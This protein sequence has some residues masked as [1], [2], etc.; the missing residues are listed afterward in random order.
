M[1]FGL[2]YVFSEFGDT[3]QAQVFH[4]FLEEVEAAEALGFD[5]VW[6]PSIIFPSTACWATR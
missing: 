5:S 1:K 4:E 6:I 2:M 3:P